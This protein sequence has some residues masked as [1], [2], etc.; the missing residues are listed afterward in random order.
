[1]KKKFFSDGTRVLAAFTI[2]IGAIATCNAA[3]GGEIKGETSSEPLPP[4]GGQSL[5]SG[6]GDPYE[7]LDATTG[8]GWSF[9]AGPLP[10]SCGSSPSFSGAACAVSFRQDILDK[11]L[12][13]DGALHCAK[14]QC[15]STTSPLLPVIDVGDPMGTYESLLDKT[16]TG[17]TVK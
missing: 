15:H 9:D 8:S 11:M 4:Y 17:C 2:A 16:R 14:S 3:C 7:N 13:A 10:N 5:P 1:M 12:G 6:G